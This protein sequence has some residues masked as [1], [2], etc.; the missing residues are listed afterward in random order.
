M[1]PLAFRA[2]KIHVLTVPTRTARFYSQGTYDLEYEFPF[3]IQNRGHCP[4][5]QLRSQATPGASASRSNISMRNRDQISRRGRRA[6][7]RRRPDVL[8]VLCEG[9]AEETIKDEESG[10]EETRWFS[11][12]PS[13][14]A[15]QGRHFSVAPRTSPN[16]LPS[17]KASTRHFSR[18]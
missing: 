4:S 1:R 17:P 2:R 9:Y 18:Y 10:K 8:A 13:P 11:V 16:W 6:E 3:G 15:H 12:L 7:R 14:R 5:R